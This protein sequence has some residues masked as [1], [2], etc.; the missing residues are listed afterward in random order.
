MSINTQYSVVQGSQLYIM[1]PTVSPKV[2]VVVPGVQGLDGLGGKK[3]SIKTTSFDSVGYDEYAPGLVDPGTPGGNV[4]F[5][6]NNTT[7]QLLQKLLGL[8]VGSATSFFYGASDGT[9]APTVVANVLTPPTTGTSP[10]TF[11][12]SGWLYDGFVNEYT[13]TAQ[14]NNV[15]MAKLGVQASGARM[16]AV[17][18]ATLLV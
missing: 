5:D 2:A 9:A 14:V 3:S 18:G 15:V 12:R 10:K 7:H 17:K 16:L 1:N 11:T 8:G 4:I 6:Y 13:I